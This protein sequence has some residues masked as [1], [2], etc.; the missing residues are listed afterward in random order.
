VIS[1]EELLKS[2]DRECGSIDRPQVSG[3]NGKGVLDRTLV[4]RNG[5]WLLFELS[6]VGRAR[7][8]P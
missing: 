8:Q 3:S 5:T 4:L 6:F 1:F 2:G 7:S